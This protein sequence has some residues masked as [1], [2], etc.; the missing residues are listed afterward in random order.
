MHILRLYKTFAIHIHHHFRVK[1]SNVLLTHSH[2]YLNLLTDI[3]H[4]QASF[5]EAATFMSWKDSH[6]LSK[7]F[8][9]TLEAYLMTLYVL[10]Y[11]CTKI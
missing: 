3:S 11:V 1:Y 7:L 5:A 2:M 10:G 6:H 9:V 8:Y 4:I